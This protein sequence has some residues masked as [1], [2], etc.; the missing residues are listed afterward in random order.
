M[1]Q[2]VARRKRATLWFFL[3]LMV[4]GVF[5]LFYPAYGSTIS[6]IRQNEVIREYTSEVAEV[7]EEMLAAAREY[8][9]SLGFHTEEEYMKQLKTPGTDVIASVSVPSVGILQPIFHTED[10][11][12]LMRGVGHMGYTHLP[13]GGEGTLSSLTGHTGVP[14][15]KIF[16]PLHNIELGDLI[17]I[18]VAGDELFYKTIEKEVISPTQTDRLQP[19]EGKDLIALLTCTPYSVNTHR[20][21]V[22]AERT[23]RPSEEEL[24]NMDVKDPVSWWWVA[25][26]ALSLVGVIA[27]GV[28]GFRNLKKQFPDKPLVDSHDQPAPL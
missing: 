28:S 3:V 21:L 26:M 20:L 22:I 11:D 10:E 9:Q 2:R 23:D 7:D 5:V 17:I 4:A 18:K 14:G 8:N 27:L 1:N 16:D 25:P 19:R 6:A 24:G 12:V 13:V 15:K